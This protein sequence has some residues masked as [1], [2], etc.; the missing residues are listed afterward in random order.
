MAELSM[1]EGMY[2]LFMEFG[3]AVEE[4]ES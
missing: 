1:N 3:N 4:A 2:R